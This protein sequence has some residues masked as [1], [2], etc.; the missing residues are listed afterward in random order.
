MDQNSQN[1]EGLLS[2]EELL[3]VIWPNEKSRPCLRTLREFQAK[4]MVPYVKLGRLV[5]FDPAKV[6][7]A[8]EKRFTVEAA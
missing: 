3:S 7:R 5:Y 6:R 2:A 8:L 4:R 1:P